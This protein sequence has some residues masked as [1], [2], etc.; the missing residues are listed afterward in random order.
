MNRVA[1]LSCSTGWKILC[2]LPER[3]LLRPRRTSA[4]TAQSQGGCVRR[5]RRMKILC[6]VIPHPRTSLLPPDIHLQDFFVKGFRRH[7]SM[8]RVPSRN[9]VVFG[10]N[11]LRSSL[12]EFSKATVED[13]GG[14]NPLNVHG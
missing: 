6:I 3:A 1:L 7:S 11:C 13:V 2:M 10:M 4:E 5:F 9:I 14:G 12:I 8:S